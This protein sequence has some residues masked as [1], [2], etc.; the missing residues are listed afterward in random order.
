MSIDNSK[1]GGRVSA[2]LL[3]VRTMAGRY[4]L[5]DREEICSAAAAYL[6]ADAAPLDYAKAPEQC[7]RILTVRL[8]A[9]DREAFACLWLNNRHGVIG[10]D[11]LFHGALDRASV[12]PQVVARHALT[13]NAAAVILAHNHP[14][15]TPEP[16]AADELITKRLREALQ[17]LD[18]RV[19]DHMIVTAAGITSFSERGLL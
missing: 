9:L 15:G 13:R 5:A 2:P 14:S 16:S 1:M 11:V 19:V 12:S 17:L 18:V 3:H 7:R 6:V 8:A 10:L 4:R